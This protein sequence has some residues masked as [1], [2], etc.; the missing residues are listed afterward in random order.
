[1]VKG[2]TGITGNLHVGGT[3]TTYGFSNIC[4]NISVYGSTPDTTNTSNKVN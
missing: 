1:M 2:G 4:G 3:F